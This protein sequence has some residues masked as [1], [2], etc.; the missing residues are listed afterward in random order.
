MVLLTF[1]VDI[2][3]SQLRVSCDTTI[4]GT[5]ALKAV[6]AARQLGF[7]D[8]A[9][10][11]LTIDELKHLVEAG[12]CPIV[13]V[14]LLPIDAHDDF[15]A[16][17]V[18]EFRKRDVLVLDPLIGERAIPLQVFGTAWGMRH[19]LAILIGNVELFAGIG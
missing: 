19:N 3:E 5:D 17:V 18:T 8:S 11:T 4:L 2:P 12:H 1:G 6:D 13:F 15:H 7:N 9:K 10:Y 14:S 16:L